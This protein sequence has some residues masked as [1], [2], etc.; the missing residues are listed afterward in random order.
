MS[1][2]STQIALGGVFSALCLLIMFLTGMVP[3]AVYAL[4][5]LAG[6]MLV[7]VRVEIGRKAAMMVYVSVSLL[8]ILIVPEKEAVLL[9]IAFF[10][11]YAIVKDLLD[12]IGPFA[13]RWAAKLLLFNVT[14]VGSTLFGFYVLGMTELLEDLGE[15]GALLTG[16]FLLACNGVYLLYDLAL[17]RYIH[18]YIH[19]FK[20]T[21]L[22]R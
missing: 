17:G 12:A 2:K 19:W 15:W 13:L 9:F 14:T 6:A 4:P 18:L 8:S 22:R 16:L 7:A 3:F 20:P 1:K 21:F 10:G 5:A 11:Y